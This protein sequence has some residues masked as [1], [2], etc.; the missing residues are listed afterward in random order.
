MS[1]DDDS[2][3]ASSSAYS[4]PREVVVS[5]A[6]NGVQQGPAML[7]PSLFPGRAPTFWFES[8]PGNRD[9]GRS[10]LHSADAATVMPFVGPSPCVRLELK[11]NCIRHAFK[12]NG[13]TVN[14]AVPGALLLVVWMRHISEELLNVLPNNAIINHFPGSWTLGRKDSLWRIF[15]T[16]IRRLGAMR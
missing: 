9:G 6:K 10:E 15:Q 4:T 12:R 7:F 8:P 1:D 14:D 16:Q 11:A 3:V 5:Q 2:S 13:F